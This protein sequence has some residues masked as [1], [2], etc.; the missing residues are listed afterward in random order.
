MATLIDV[1]ARDKLLR[2]INDIPKESP[3]PGDSV[4]KSTL[5]AIV[6]EE[7][8]TELLAFL[9]AHN[10]IYEVPDGTGDLICNDLIDGKYNGLGRK[11]RCAN[12]TGYHTGDFTMVKKNHWREPI[13]LCERH[14]IEWLNDNR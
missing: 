2:K 13:Y 11:D 10:V 6:G 8:R 5:E 12:D 9:K 7:N 14:Y 3:H 4:Q 1:A